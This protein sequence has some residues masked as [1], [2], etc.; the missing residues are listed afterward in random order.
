MN[1]KQLDRMFLMLPCL[2]FFTITGD[3]KSDQH[4]GTSKDI[5]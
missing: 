2:L 3:A 1:S 5:K 4:N